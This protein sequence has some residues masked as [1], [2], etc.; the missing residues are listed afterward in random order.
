M[1]VEKVI[2]TTD[3]L[4]Y[5]FQNSQYIN[6]ET[7]E[8]VQEGDTCTVWRR[9]NRVTTI[10]TNNILIK[11]ARSF[12]TV[13]R[14]GKAKKIYEEKGLSGYPT[15][16]AGIVSDVLG[17]AIT[18][19]VVDS[20]LSKIAIDLIG[21]NGVWLWIEKNV[22][23]RYSKPVWHYD[24]NQAYRW[25][26]KMGL[27]S[28]IEPYQNHWGFVGV[29][30]LEDSKRDLPSC[31][32]R[33]YIMVDHEDVRYYGLKG[34]WVSRVGFDDLS[35]SLTP[36]FEIIRDWFDE[37]IYK[38][39]TQMYWRLFAM[40]EGATA[41]RYERG[42][43][44]SQ[45]N[46][47]GR[48]RNPVWATLITHRVMRK[49]HQVMLHGGIQCFV[50]SV[51]IPYEMKTSNAIGEW[52]LESYFDNGVYIKAP[53]IYDSLPR[54]T[55][56]PSDSWYRHSGIMEGYQQ[57]IPSR[58]ESWIEKHESLPDNFVRIKV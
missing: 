24:L 28:N 25:G 26:S 55:L 3:L 36:M 33:D 16:P 7:G 29:L 9:N 14:A 49:V 58:K 15:S 27:P 31:L 19:G 37:R 44:K 17:R 22:N 2:Y 34:H 39:A 32:E 48:F 4:D 6:E 20:P 42:E 35:V 52:E 11:S 30:E 57:S 21:T 51:L 54:S 1:K 40:G 12:G 18:T 10:Y 41:T 38:K 5:D 47:G 50:D 43:I 13:E 23:G 46:T 53:G 45:W 56:K 8:V